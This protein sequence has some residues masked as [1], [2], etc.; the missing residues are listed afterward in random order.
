MAKLLLAQGQKVAQVV[1]MDSKLADPDKRPPFDEDP[2]I[3]MSLF[4]RDLGALNA[5]DLPL[6]AKEL[7]DLS[8]EKQLKFLLE[9][10]QSRDLI[11]R[12]MQAE[13]F[14]P[15]YQ[16][17]RNNFKAMGNYVHHGKVQPMTLFRAAEWLWPDRMD[18]EMGWGKVTEA[19]GLDVRVVPGNHYSMLQKPHARV[20]AQRVNA[21]LNEA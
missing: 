18:P 6:D 16:V 8:F 2:A 1:L 11:S 12:E 5:Q 13:Q 14:L 17:F 9:L 10:L 7:R 19:G 21:C 15:L 20:L 4:A 3:Y